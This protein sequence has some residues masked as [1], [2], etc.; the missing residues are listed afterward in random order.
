MTPHLKGYRKRQKR[1]ALTLVLCPNYKKLQVDKK[2]VVNFIPVRL[3][4]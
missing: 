2:L 4:V 3:E 1:G